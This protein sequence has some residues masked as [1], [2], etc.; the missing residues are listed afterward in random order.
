MRV[1]RKGHPCLLRPSTARHIHSL[2]QTPPI[3][4]K[5]RHACAHSL[6]GTHAG[7]DNMTRTESGPHSSNKVTGSG[8]RMAIA[9]RIVGC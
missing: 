8:F 9:S 3:E 5:N 1:A 4:K 7:A 2:D 6:L